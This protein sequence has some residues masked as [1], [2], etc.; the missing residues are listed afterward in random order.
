MEWTKLAGVKGE[1]VL[2]PSK[3]GNHKIIILYLLVMSV[4]IHTF[5]CL[6]I[7]LSH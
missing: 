1:A 5:L 7:A 6:S 3:D 2:F 4:E